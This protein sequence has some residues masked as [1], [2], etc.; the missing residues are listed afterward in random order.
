MKSFKQYLAEENQTVQCDINGIC[1]VI[2]GYESARNE[3]KI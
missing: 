3:E 1:K 2:K